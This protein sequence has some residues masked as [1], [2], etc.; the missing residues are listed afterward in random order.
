[1]LFKLLVLMGQ[2]Q[3]RDSNFLSFSGEGNSAPS[4]KIKKCKNSTQIIFLSILMIAMK[5]FNPLLLEKISLNSFFSPNNLLQMK[6]AN[7][8]VRICQM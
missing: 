7:G 6:T 2:M 1:M 4:L 8:W 5:E 3:P